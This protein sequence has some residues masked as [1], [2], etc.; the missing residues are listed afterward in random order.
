VLA[1]RESWVLRKRLEPVL[2]QLASPRQESARQAEEPVGRP[3]KM[4]EANRWR[5][6]CCGILAA[7]KPKR[8]RQPGQHFAGRKK[9]QGRIGA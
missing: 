8:L 1:A 3:R 6:L 7:T 4:A 5:C 2:E 9:S